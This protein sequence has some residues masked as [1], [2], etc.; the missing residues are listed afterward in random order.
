MCVISL[1]P[2]S[3]TRQRFYFSPRA[4]REYCIKEALIYIYCLV[5]SN[6]I[7]I[8]N[9]KTKW[10]M[11]FDKQYVL[12]PVLLGK[13]YNLYDHSEWAC[14]P[15]FW[16]PMEVTWNMTE[17][18][19]NKNLAG[20]HIPDNFPLVSTELNLK[21]TVYICIFW[22]RNNAVTKLSLLIPFQWFDTGDVTQLA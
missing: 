13:Q 8:R 18:L 3:L 2:P 7:C 16:V 11:W 9:V 10:W 14:R 12:V 19:C 1:G 4:H 5:H 22:T 15:F 21:Y 20:W 6:L 17:S